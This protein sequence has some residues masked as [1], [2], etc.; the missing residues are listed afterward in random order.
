MPRTALILILSLAAPPAAAQDL[1]APVAGTLPAGTRTQPGAVQGQPPRLLHLHRPLTGVEAGLDFDPKTPEAM[2]VQAAIQAASV[3]TLFPDP[4]H[5]F[6][7]PIADPDFLDAARF[8]EI[9]FASTVI[10][11]TG[12]NTAKVTGDL[13][14]RGV[15]RPAVLDVTCNGGRGNL[16][17]DPAG[18]RIGLSATGS[19]N[20]SDFGM[21]WGSGTR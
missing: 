12:E 21:S 4:A 16:P 20:R 11:R 6:D 19:L 17:M 10:E 13:T 18:A 5:D 7:A 3:G 9:T 2:K 1:P 8:P 15:T 14:L